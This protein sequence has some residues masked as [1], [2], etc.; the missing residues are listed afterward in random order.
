MLILN[1]VRQYAFSVE[2]EAIFQ[3]WD[4]FLESKIHIAKTNANKQ[5]RFQ[6][7]KVICHPHHTKHNFDQSDLWQENGK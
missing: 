5:S 3:D 4:S 7:T 6:K 1:P 2:S